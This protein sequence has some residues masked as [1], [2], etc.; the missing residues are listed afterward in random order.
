MVYA[1]T[2]YP[3]ERRRRNQRTRKIPYMAILKGHKIAP[4]KQQDVMSRTHPTFFTYFSLRE[5]GLLTGQYPIM[6]L[7][8]TGCD[9]EGKVHSTS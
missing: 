7:P 4:G 6:R 2:D 1:I 3:V 9:K 8:I 5:T